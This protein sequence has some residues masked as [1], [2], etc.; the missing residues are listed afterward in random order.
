MNEN[1]GGKKYDNS[2]MLWENTRKS[3]DNQPDVRGK[4]TINGVEMEIAGWYRDGQKGPFTSL[5]FKPAEPTGQRS[6]APAGKPMGGRSAQPAANRAPSRN[7]SAS[8][9]TPAEMAYDDDIPF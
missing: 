5:A 3:A 7:A 1:S 8:R 2:G 6:G 9:R 4:C